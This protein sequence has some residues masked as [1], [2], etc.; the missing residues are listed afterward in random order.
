MN[1]RP[2]QYAPAM[3]N[4][5]AQGLY[6]VFL[7]AALL[8]CSCTS[9]ERSLM[10]HQDLDDG[11]E[12]LYQRNGQQTWFSA[13]VPGCIHTDLLE[14]G[15]IPDPFYGCNEHEVQ[16][17]GRQDWAYRKTFMVDEA[18]LEARAIQLVFE[19][20]DTYAAVRLNG[21]ELFQSDNMFHPWEVDC[22]EHLRPGEN[23]LEVLFSSAEE[24]FI[25]D[26]IALGYPLPGGRWV[27]ARKAAY[28]FGWDWGPT[29]ITAGI[30]LP[31]YLRVLHSHYP[32]DIQ[33]FTTYLEEEEAGIRAE[34]HIEAAFAEEAL[35]R[36]WDLSGSTVYAEESIGLLPATEQYVVDFVIRDPILWWTHDLGE[37][38]LYELMVEIQ[39]AS[40]HVHRE[41]IPYGLRTIEVVTETD[42]HGESFFFRLNGLPVFMKG[43]NYIPQHSFITAVTDD[44]YR[45]LIDHA[46]ASNMNML[47]VWGGGIYER[48]L[49]Y[50]LCDRRGILVWQDFMFACAMY[51]G[52]DDFVESVRREAEY[53]VRRLR[54]HASL[55]MWC[56]NNE[57]DEGWHNWQWQR[58]HQ[59]QAADSARIW[60]DYLRVFHD[61]LPG[62]VEAVDPGRHYLHTSP[63][64]GWGHEESSREGP[65]HYWGVWWG[66]EP[67]EMYLEKVPRFMSEYGFQAMPAMSTIR[68]F[69]AEQEDSLFSDALRCHQKHPTGYETI[70]EYMAREGLY[71]ASLEEYLYM[72]QLVQARGV[73]MAIEAHR[74]D[75]PRCMGSLYWQLNDCWPV[76]SWS[77]IDVNGNWKALQYTVRQ[78][79]D[80]IMLSFLE[81]DGQIRLHVVSGL[82]EDRRGFLQWHLVDMDN[83][84]FSLY[85]NDLEVA[86]NTSLEVITLSAEKLRV[87]HDLD[88]M[89]LEAVF[90]TEDGRVYRNRKFLEGLGRLRLPESQPEWHIR[91]GE[92]GFYI[93]LH[94]SAFTAFVHLYLAEHHAWFDDNFFH[95]LPGETKTVF[96]RS[97]LPYDAFSEQLRL[98][99]MTTII[100]KK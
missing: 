65:A 1:R 8:L 25:E 70:T 69:Q 39:T 2:T 68:Q 10:T 46:L 24:R 88:A 37:P 90:S 94:S 92:D 36:V 54:N 77:G 73:G 58:V 26:S 35:V 19:G 48:D 20:L 55:A 74:R 60:S 89:M 86:A 57:V 13:S 93:D 40:G 23:L 21:Q 56:G 71:P 34:L 41:H 98:Q 32:R 82:P 5:G 6:H 91:S 72:S 75:K 96:C 64:H 18:L 45:Q 42:T 83:N 11:W 95:L 31:V 33:L 99:H 14:H 61:L 63:V 3:K 79:Y 67:F 85:E 84:R 43:A 81:Q 7:V 53:Q 87:S 27:F 47:R 22:L 28:H 78:L 52:D 50:G 62:I 80:D 29:L 4:P 9:G 30:H 59:I 97:D 17:V 12:F 100:Q 66:M 49:F 76:T 44:D 38:H 15:L 16:W 51:P